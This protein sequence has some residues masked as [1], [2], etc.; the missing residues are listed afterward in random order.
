M[1]ALLGAGLLVGTFG[2]IFAIVVGSASLGLLCCV[3][4][5]NCCYDEPKVQSSLPDAQPGV[6][7]TVELE[8]VHTQDAV[9]PS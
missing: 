7:P 2:W 4:K 1:C 3:F 6:Q 5:E 8:S 9:P